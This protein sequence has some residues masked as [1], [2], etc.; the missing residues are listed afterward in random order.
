MDQKATLEAGMLTITELGRVF[1]VVP[2][3]R[4]MKVAG[5]EQDPND[6]LNRVK[7]EEEL[8]EIGADLYMNSVIHGEIAYEVQ[9]GFV[10]RA[11]PKSGA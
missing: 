4:F 7:T 8:V 1:A 10:G 11:E 6:L 2:A 9:P 5:D 3:V